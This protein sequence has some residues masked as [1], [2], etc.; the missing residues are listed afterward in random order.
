MVH[1]IN[2]D[3]PCLELSSALKPGGGLGDHFN[4]ERNSDQDIARATLD[5]IECMLSYIYLFRKRLRELTELVQPGAD[6][7][8]DVTAQP[9]HF[10]SHS[11]AAEVVSRPRP[12]LKDPGSN[13]HGNGNGNGSS[14]GNGSHSNGNGNGSQNGNGNSEPDAVPTAPE[15]ES[16]GSTGNNGANGDHE[17]SKPAIFGVR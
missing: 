6:E 16:N 5:L 1:Q 9:G 2:T 7:M 13:G 12:H 4:L 14:N 8:V 3:R 10:Q 11:R 15:A 17:E